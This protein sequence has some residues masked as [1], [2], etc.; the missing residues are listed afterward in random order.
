VQDP[1]EGV[2]LPE[3]HG[4]SLEYG[5]TFDPDEDVSFV[6]ARFFAIY[7]YGRIWHNSAPKALRF[8]VE[9]AAGSTVTPD[10]SLIASANML[11][12]YYPWL[13]PNRTF[14]PYVEGGIGVIYTGFRVKGEGLH[15]NFNPQLGVGME[16]PRE[17]GKNPF[18]ALRLHHI[19]NGNLY[20]NNR[21]VNSVLLQVGHYF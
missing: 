13:K 2:R 20:H 19:S 4:A 9:G 6:V 12:M 7:D 1:A 5:Y 8:K 15:W 17:D 14:R 3:V 16:L 18:A 11:A 10:A 21:G